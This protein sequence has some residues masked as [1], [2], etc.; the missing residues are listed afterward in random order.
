MERILLGRTGLQVH[1][2]GLGGIP[3]QRLD[4]REA[5]EVVLHAIDLGVDFIDTAR[6]Y[7]N[8]ERRIGLALKASDRKVVL[9]SKSYGKTSEE[10]FPAL[11]NSAVHA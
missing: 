10:I 8:S 1:R 5:V 9:S 6:G 4:E 7:T 11:R 3:I 2:L